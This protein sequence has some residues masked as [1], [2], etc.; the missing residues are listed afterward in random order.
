MNKTNKQIN[1]Q[2]WSDEVKDAVG[3]FWVNFWFN[4]VFNVDSPDVMLSNLIDLVNEV[5]KCN[6]EACERIDVKDAY[7]TVLDNPPERY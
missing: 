3:T 4:A 7:Q 5:T 6:C 2:K 1:N